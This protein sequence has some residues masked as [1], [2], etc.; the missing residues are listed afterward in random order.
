[1]DPSSNALADPTAD[2]D[3]FD[4]FIHNYDDPTNKPHDESA[5]L[6]GGCNALLPLRSLDGADT[7]EAM[8]TV[9]R[10]NLFDSLSSGSLALGDSVRPYC[11]A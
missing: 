10:A 7:L 6:Q 5:F 3:A 11:I 2:G 8:Y 4:E 9:S 1:M